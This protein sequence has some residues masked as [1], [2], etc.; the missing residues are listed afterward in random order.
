MAKYTKIGFI[1]SGKMAG[2]II[3]GL[4]KTGFA[5]AQNLMATQAEPEG[6]QEKSKEL[7]IRI[8]L[9]NKELVKWADVVFIATK[10]NQVLG[11]IEEIKPYVIP[12][13]LI[14]S[15]AA[16]VNTVKLEAN[17]PE[18]THVVRVMPNTPALVG[19]GMSGMVGGKCAESEDLEF[20]KNLLSTIGRCIVVD[21][22][23]QIDI[24]TAISGSGP[25]FFYKVINEIARAGEKL[26][27]DYE[28]ALLL[29]IQ[30][31][32]GSA[33]MALNREVSMEQLI[34]NVATK[35]GCTAVGVDCMNENN[36]EKLFYD[37][38][39]STTKKAHAL[40]G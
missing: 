11:V 33:K 18:G 13:K 20:V 26:G 6:V 5:E 12:E 19:E 28:K 35:G 37:V 17:L 16:G 32:I 38:I 3:R 30:T 8:I 2:A 23:T 1:G 29:S 25:A 9:D 14:V 22:E 24:V 27:M 21:D 7:G 4:I 10:P 36:T 15:I 31:A 34:A 39:E 40:G